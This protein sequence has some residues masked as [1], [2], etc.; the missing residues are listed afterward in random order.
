MAIKKITISVKYKEEGSEM[1]H[2]IKP[3]TIETD[4]EL[5]KILDAIRKFDSEVTGKQSLM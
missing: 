2:T 5:G 4:A 1:T 3:D